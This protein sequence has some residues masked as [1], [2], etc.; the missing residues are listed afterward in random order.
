MII[1]RENNV[2]VARYQGREVYGSSFTDAIGKMIGLL[3][4]EKLPEDKFQAF[5]AELPE[6]VKLL[7]RGGMADWRQVLPEWYAKSYVE[8]NHV[9]RGACA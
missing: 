8:N 5:F 6:R 9:Q 2:Y 4:L 1:T 7:V 3:E